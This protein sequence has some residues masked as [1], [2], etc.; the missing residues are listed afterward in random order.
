MRSFGLR[1][2]ALAIS[3]IWRRDSGRSPTRARGLT[4]SQPTRASSSSA[5]RRCA[6]W[7]IRPKRVGGRVMLMLSATERS[8]STDSSWKTV[9]MPTALAACGVVERDRLAGED[10][11]CP[12]RA[13]TTPETILISVDFPAP[14][15]PSTAWIEDGLVDEVDLGK[16]RDAA[17]GLADTPRMLQRAARRTSRSRDC[18]S[19]RKKTRRRRSAGGA[20][21]QATIPGCRRSAP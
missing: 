17:V 1:P 7:S 20:R 3:T 12:R 9:T 15:S 19:P 14:F 2:S 13:S 8:G 18:P 4:S 10:D 11:R 16:R 5:R 21:C 6:R